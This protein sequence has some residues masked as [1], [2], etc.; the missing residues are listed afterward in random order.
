[1]KKKKIIV[2]SILLILG[3]VLVLWISGI[4]PKQI[5]RISA[6]NYLEKN[7]PKKKYEYVDIEWCS[8]MDGYLV[9]YKDE[10]NDI[11]G[12]IMPNKY[13]PIR[14]GQ[15]TFALEDSYRIEYGSGITDINDVY[16]HSITNDYKDIRSL[17]Q[18]Y[19][20]EQAQKDNC[21][22]IGAMVHNDNLYKEFMNK[23]NK[24][25]NAYIRVVQSTAEGDVFIIDLLY[26]ARNNKIHL[27][28]DNTRDKFS[29]HEDRTIKYKTYEKTG[30]WNYQN[31]R[32]WVA[33]NGEL[34]NATNKDYNINSDELF[35][36][37][38][39]N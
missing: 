10:N 19:S 1:M 26:E 23:Y 16:N 38:M 25:E 17:P 20:K 13:F 4:I 27:I 34:P 5:A 39:I 30:V 11:F 22:V 6:T 29:A 33:Y 28:K 9:R 2:I 31:S 32:Y 21:F 24:K 15:G 18:D 36:I 7:F 37:T 35:I 8:S 3:V 12:L 14:P